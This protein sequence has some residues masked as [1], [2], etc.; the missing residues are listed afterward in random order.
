V[1]PASKAHNLTAICEPTVQKM[2]KPQRLTNLWASTACY[3]DS[4]TFRSIIIIISSIII[5]I[6][7]SSSISRMSL[8]C[9]DM[10]EWTVEGMSVETDARDGNCHIS[11]LNLRV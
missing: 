3:R 11:P 7:T 6:I 9:Y 8:S 10:Y 2:W 1:R 4:F 5:I